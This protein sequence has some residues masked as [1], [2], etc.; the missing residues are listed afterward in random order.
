MPERTFIGVEGNYNHN[1]P[2]PEDLANVR[3]VPNGPNIRQVYEQTR[4]LLVPSEYE[5]WSRCAIEASTS[6]IPV[7]A[8]PTP[9]LLES[10]GEA[11]IFAD[12]GDTVAWLRNIEN[13]DE[14][15]TYQ[16]ASDAVRARAAYHEERSNAE[17]L[18]LENAL[19]EVR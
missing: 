2:P 11:G 4:I 10:L 19:Y 12:Q 14:P 18:C 13:L 5:S 7:I 3:I 17:L 1:E 15:R 6:G 8:A 9:G 16:A